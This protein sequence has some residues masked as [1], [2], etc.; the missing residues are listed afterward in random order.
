M[1]GGSAH[2]Y[3]IIPSGKPLDMYGFIEGDFWWTYIGGTWI[4]VDSGDC[5]ISNLTFKNVV[6]TPELQPNNVEGLTTYKIL[7]S[8]TANFQAITKIEYDKATV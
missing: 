1:H 2:N 8:T 5:N 6:D 4:R 3:P 7:G